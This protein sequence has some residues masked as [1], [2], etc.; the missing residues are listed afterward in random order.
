MGPTGLVI[1]DAV[2]LT[3]SK[4]SNHFLYLQSIFYINS[5]KW[6]AEALEIVMC[7]V[8]KI[9]LKRRNATRNEIK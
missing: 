4:I 5:I 7:D 2:K 8:I 1:H 6:A 3:M 9:R